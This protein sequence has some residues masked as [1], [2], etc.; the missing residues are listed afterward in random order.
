MRQHFSALA[1]ETDRPILVYNIPYRTGVNLANDTLL[2]L[3]DDHAHI[4]GVKDCCADPAQSVELLRRRKPGF[5][6]LTGE[7]ALFYGAL[8]HGADGGVLATAQVDPAAFAA[9]RDAVLA[10]RLDDARAR[11]DRLVY[12]VRLLF[13]EP[14]P[15]PIK[16]VLWRL[17]LIASPELRLPMT[18]ISPTLA[19]R[20]DALLPKQRAA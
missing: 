5:S 6:V 7:D 19:A 14:N 15:A 12:L 17:G 1:R 2:R 16:H 13:A 9:V 4:M 10:G 3:A 11:W 20:L 8:V 18:G